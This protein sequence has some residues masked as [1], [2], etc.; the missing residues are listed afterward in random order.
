MDTISR[1]LRSPTTP[2]FVCSKR[3]DSRSKELE[4]GTII[5]K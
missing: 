3:S 1:E 4:S 2:P 5:K